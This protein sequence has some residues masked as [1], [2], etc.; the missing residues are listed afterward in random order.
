M[1]DSRSSGILLHPT[2]L[3]SPYGIGDLGDGAYRFVD[4][5][6]SSDQKIWQILPLGP[7]GAGNSPYSSYSALAGNPLLINLDLL[8]KDGLL[9][10]DQINRAKGV[11]AH[12]DAGWVNY[13]LVLREKY[14]YFAKAFEA[15][16]T[17]STTDTYYQKFLQ[18]TKDY[19]YWLDDYALYMALKDENSNQPWFKW[20]KAVAKRETQAIADWTDKLS[21]QIKYQKFLQFS[22]F[23]QWSNLKKYANDRGV[24]IFGDIPIY[25]A[26]DSVDVWAN[27]ELFCLDGKGEASLMAGVP[28]DYFSATGQ[29]WGNPVYDWEKLKATNFAWWIQRIKGMLEYVDIMRIDHFRGFEAYWAVP[30]GETTAMNGKWLKAPGDEFFDL[31][32]KELGDLPI[33]AEDLGVITP[34]VEALRDKYDFPGMKILHFAFD[35]DRENVFLPFNYTNPNCVVYTGTHDNNT[36][37]GWFDQRSHDER[38]RVIDYIECIGN[39]GI[40][41]SM[42]SLAMSSVAKMAVFPAQDILGLGTSAKMNTPGTVDNNWAWRYTEGALHDGI[43]GHLRYITYLYGR[44]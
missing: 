22:F 37:V 43:T 29:L 6:Q 23:S 42:I 44:K 28:P 13:D 12:V 11:F 14:I 17:K 21:E 10:Q 5:L 41:W 20:D 36:T 7:T 15:F 30:Q 34:E 24:K 27:Q 32:Q 25:V 3:P 31:L 1:L 18:F 9:T 33:V 4:F 2:S 39:K 19:S 35:D 38:Q 16:K 40:H 26:H 8:H